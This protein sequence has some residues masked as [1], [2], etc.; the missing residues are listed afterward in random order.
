MCLIT[1]SLTPT[2]SSIIM[3]FLSTRNFSL[4]MIGLINSKTNT[5]LLF[6]SLRRPPKSWWIKY[7]ILALNTKIKS[8]FT[9]NSMP[10]PREHKIMHLSRKDFIARLSLKKI[11]SVVIE[12]KSL[13]GILKLNLIKAKS[14]QSLWSEITNGDKKNRILLKNKW[15]KRKFYKKRN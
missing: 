3:L 14:L 1:M 13:Q 2:S 7:S 4:M 6:N 11:L 8:I 15:R 5:P 9:M 12:I 10:P